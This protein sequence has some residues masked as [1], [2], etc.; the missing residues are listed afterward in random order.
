MTQNL[1]EIEYRIYT[2][3]RDVWEIPIGYAPHTDK[4][5]S[6]PWLS[7]MAPISTKT[8]KTKLASNPAGPSTATCY[9]RIRLWGLPQKDLS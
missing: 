6:M 5:C 9:S 7:E 4:L 8:G 1:D 2:P 3:C